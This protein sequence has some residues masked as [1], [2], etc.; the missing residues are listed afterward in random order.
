M[1]C[2]SC[3]TEAESSFSKIRLYVLEES[4]SWQVHTASPGCCQ[5]RAL[6]C[7]QQIY[8]PSST[9][10]EWPVQLH[11]AIGSE[12]PGLAVLCFVVTVLKLLIILSLNSDFVKE[13]CWNNRAWVTAEGWWLRDSFMWVLPPVASPSFQGQVLVARLPPSGIWAPHFPLPTLLSLTSSTRSKGRTA[14]GGQHPATTH[15]P[16]QVPGEDMERGGVGWVC[17][18]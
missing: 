18:P 12:G 5:I 2:L 13:V 16:W 4:Q 9:S 14:G 6:W 7:H 11:I 17:T 1:S 3:L 10:Q 8:F 15:H